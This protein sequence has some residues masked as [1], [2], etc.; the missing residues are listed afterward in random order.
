M[1]TIGHVGSP[2]PAGPHGTTGRRRVPRFGRAVADVVVGVV[3]V[4]AAVVAAPVSGRW[5]ARWGAR[6]DEVAAPLLGDDLVPEPVLDH[7]RAVTVDAPVEDVW[8]WVAQIGQGRGGLY[9]YDGLENLVGCGIRSADRILPEHQ[10]VRPGVLVRLGPEGYPCFRVVAVQPPTTLVTAG[11]DP[12]PP[13]EVVPASSG[14]AGTWQW[15]L[16]PEDGGRRTRLVVRQ[17]LLVPPSQ[18][19]LWSLVEVVG[20][21]IDRRMLRGIARRAGRR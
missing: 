15:S 20:F 11:A 21:V 19:L 2:S 7:T 16:R 8:P 4:G 14:T 10:D 6:T 18:R 12:R 9:S 5:Y 17:C 1:D 3:Q 13:H